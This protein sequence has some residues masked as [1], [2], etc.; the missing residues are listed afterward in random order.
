MNARRSEF[1]FQVRLNFV[2]W[3]INGMSVM[4]K[5]YCIVIP[6]ITQKHKIPSNITTTS[7]SMWKGKYWSI[8]NT[9]IGKER[10]NSYKKNEEISGW[11]AHTNTQKLH[12]NIS[13]I[14]DVYLDQNENKCM[15]TLKVWEAQIQIKWVKKKINI[16]NNYSHPK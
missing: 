10:R 7:E 8:D 14:T 15:W 9:K 3:N 1:D 5:E 6:L 13:M 16:R 2:S 4:W 12:W 11:K